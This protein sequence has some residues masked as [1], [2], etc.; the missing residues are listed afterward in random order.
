MMRRHLTPI[1]ALAAAALLPACATPPATPVPAGAQRM[2]AREIRALFAHP[3]RLDNGV[4]GGLT[5]R[6]APDGTVEFGMRMFS[7]RRT[8]TWRVDDDGLCVRVETD[9]WICGPL[10]RLGSGRFYFDVPQYD[11][12]YNTLTVRE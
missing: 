7:A 9:P 1:L 12:D 2:E 8:G 10:H 6:F 3:T 4:R 5:Y 11:Q